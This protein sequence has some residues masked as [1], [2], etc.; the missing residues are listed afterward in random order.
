MNEDII[1]KKELNFILKFIHINEDL[2][3]ENRISPNRKHITLHKES[4]LPNLFFDIKKRIL[5]KENILNNCN[6]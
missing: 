5:S 3:M 1:S 4:N 6:Y 2:F